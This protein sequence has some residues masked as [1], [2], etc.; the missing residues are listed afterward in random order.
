MTQRIERLRIVSDEL[1]AAVCAVQ[2]ARTPRSEA[3]RAARRRQGRGPALWLS[4]LLVCSEC[5]S[6]YVQYGRTDYVCSGFHNGSTRSANSRRRGKRGI[7]PAYQRRR[8]AFRA[9]SSSEHIARLR[10][11]SSRSSRAA[12]SAGRSASRSHAAPRRPSRARGSPPADGDP[13]P[14]AA[15]DYL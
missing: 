10:N 14:R 11:A 3:I 12:S 4:S 5:G 7:A 2:N 9:P 15:H 8:R 6:N 13:L 1:W